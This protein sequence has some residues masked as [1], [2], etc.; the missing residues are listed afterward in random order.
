M[1][2]IADKRFPD[3]YSS[4]VLDVLKAMSMTDMKTLKIVGSSSVRSQLYAGD[5]DAIERVNA[6]SAK[7]VAKRLKQVVKQMRS[8][9]YAVIGEIK[10]GE[11]PEWNVFRPNAR[12][13]D[14]KILDFSI[15]E[16]QAKVDLLRSE[17]VLTAEESKT[18]N[19]LLERATNEFDFIYAKKSI[20]FHILRWTPSEILEGAKLIRGNQIV[21][22]EDAILSGGMIKLDAVANVHD[23][24]TEFSV[25]YD[26]FED[27]KR[28]T[29]T[30]VPLVRGLEEDI[31]FYQETNVFKALKRIF[32]L[33]KHFRET[34]IIEA[35]IPILN[36]DLGRLYQIIND[37]KTISFLLEHHRYTNKLD[38]IRSQ[39]DEVRHRL[40]NIYQLKDFLRAEHDIIGSI[41]S[42]L[43]TPVPKLKQKLDALVD[44]LQSI[45]D[46]NTMKQLEELRKKGV[47]MM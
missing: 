25:I 4:A 9:R 3:N 7:D 13:E 42:L 28:I 10:C 36:G 20:R 8:L 32:S 43:K 45:L 2:L 31:A 16:S 46:K 39:I 19:E 15:K 23:R 38:A 40:G 24:F 5:Y 47:R 17:H 26:V 44:W 33:A 6:K 35:L 21:K 22:L 30:P 12:V 37:I 41:I 29:Q 18:T 27:G 1:D 11:I 14:N 34:R